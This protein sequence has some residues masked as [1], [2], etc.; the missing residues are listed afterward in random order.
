MSKVGKKGQAKKSSKSAKATP[1]RPT[2]AFLTPAM[3][4]HFSLAMWTAIVNAA[5][6]QDANVVCVA[7]GD[8][9]KSFEYA[10]ANGSIYQAAK[11]DIIDAVIIYGSR[12]GTSIPEKVFHAFCHQ[13]TEKPVVSIGQPVEGI[14]AVLSD[15]YFGMYDMVQHLIHEHG[16]RRIAFIRGPENQTEA[17][18]RLKAYNDALSE[19]GIQ[20]DLDL[21]SHPG[22]WE[23]SAG[24]DAVRLFIDERNVDFD[25]IV[26]AN[27]TMALA[28]MWALRNRGLDI[29]GD[30]AVV[31][32]DSQVIAKAATPPLSTVRQ[33]LTEQC[34]HAIDILLTKLQGGEV[35]DLIEIPTMLCIRQSCGCT[36]SAVGRTT[37]KTNIDMSDTA[38][39]Y[40]KR[41]DVIAEIARIVDSTAGRWK[42][43]WSKRLID[44]FIAAIE[45]KDIEKFLHDFS[46][47]IEETIS[48]ETEINEWQRV[49]TSLRLF[50]RS[51]YSDEDHTDWIEELC[52]QARVLIGEK[53]QQIESHQS[54]IYDR[55][56]ANLRDMTRA[57]STTHD[58]D[59]F[60]EILHGNLP[61]FG[62]RSCYLSLY[63]ETIQTQ[64]DH[65]TSNPGSRRMIMA[66][67][68]N[69]RLPL[70]DEASVISSNIIP[71]QEL[72]SRNGKWSF[73]VKALKRGDE[74]L[75][76]VLFEVYPPDGRSCDMLQ[77]QISSALTYALLLQEKRQ[78]QEIL[79]QAY[80]EAEQ[81]AQEKTVE[82][83]F[84]IVDLVQAQ[85][86]LQREQFLMNTLMDQ[87]LD[88]IYF[89]DKEGRFIKVNTAFTAKHGK[90]TPDD[91]LGLTVFDLFPNEQAQKSFD[92][93]MHLFNTGEPLVG[94][95][96]KFTLPDGHEVWS[97]TT[98]IPL[99]N[100]E[101]E[102][103]GLF[104]IS[105]DI[106][107]RVQAQEAL[108]R[109]QYLLH[110]LMNN[111]P[112][113]IY[114]KD[115][116]SRFIKV[117]T[118]F[119][120]IHDKTS[121]DD[122]LG[123]TDFDLF[124]DEHAQEAYDDEMRV[125]NT[126]EPVIGKIE[127]ETWPDGRETWVSTSKLPLRDEKGIITGTFGISRDITET[128][129]AEQELRRH[130]AHL[131]A[132]NTI[133]SSTSSAV[134]YQELLKISLD[135]SLHALGPDMGLVWLNPHTVSRKLLPPENE[136]PHY[137]Y[138]PDSDELPEILVV[139]E[140]QD[141]PDDDPC[142]RFYETFLKPHGVRAS[143][144]VPIKAEEG[145]S[146]GGLCIAS[147]EPFNW[148]T[149]ETTLLKA[150][151]YQVGIASERLRLVETIREQ[152][153]QVQQIT[154]T[155]PDGVLLLDANNRVILANPAGTRDLYTL[156]KTTVGNEITHLGSCPIS[157]VLQEDIDVPWHEINANNRIFE[158]VAQP[159][160]ARGASRNWVVVIRDVTQERETQRQVQL[161]ER[162]AA[163]GQL[164]GGIAHDFNNL[165]TTIMLYA[166][167]PLR[168]QQ[169]P[170]DLK[171]P[172]ET[173][174]GESRKAADLVQQI[175]DF[176]RHAPIERHPIDLG[177]FVKEAIRV[178]QRTIP[179]NISLYIE[180]DPDEYIVEA[181]P[182]RI[183]QVLMN[184]VV[185]ARDAMQEGGVLRVGVSS[186]IVKEDDDDDDIPTPGMTPGKWF[187]LSV[188][189]TGSGIPDDI[190]P[191]I[192][193]PF[194]TTKSAGKGTGLG[195]SQVWGIVVQHEGF[196]R[197]ESTI[198]EGTEFCVYLPIRQEAEDI[199]ARYSDD[200][201]IPKGA[202]ERILL[203]ED[204]Q[205][206]R[207][208]SEELLCDLGY[209]VVT[210]KNGREALEIY[211]QNGEFDLIFTDVVMP[212][213]G[214]VAL[215]HSL[216]DMGS[217]IKTIAVTG[218]MLAE[219][220]QEL[221][222]NG[223]SGI[224]FK[225]LEV[226]EVAEEL[227]RIL[228]GNE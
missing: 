207:E 21:I 81:Q 215:L 206:V 103:I 6:E 19:A 72:V 151:G 108:H 4:D 73:V 226:K 216:R 47:C 202:G 10:N 149:E 93:D 134:D 55:Q 199:Q 91:L 33:Q 187:C 127:K 222:K 195:L 62:I 51:Q 98:K 143:I 66:F 173:I 85:E 142:Y 7:G 210:A 209:Q 78:E 3:E 107:E 220:L 228:D 9:D 20:H 69:S 128:K 182:T 79:Q 211:K 164:A 147:P 97:S 27:D 174:L 204:S 129:L 82:L 50:T 2:I 114:F 86:A 35:S 155:V 25:A 36:S 130:A 34:R 217:E 133:I 31:G 221:R 169:L 188:K 92:D 203:V 13:F 132:I 1:A 118:A 76:I 167:M 29:P 30:V 67:D 56:Y 205:H 17:E 109:E 148:T 87:T 64:D 110:I 40:S 111:S 156:A 8:L 157:E 214:G 54:L 190:L 59:Q 178:L 139:G 153:Q 135:L 201:S 219:D 65:S 183:Q 193:E 126:G 120:E 212:E 26:S 175:L 24:E 105:R 161:Q 223:V 106:T 146:V 194:F 61:R 116:E 208:V 213:V 70:E 42:T 88:S 192:F 44:S 191:H 49:V 140:W 158:I 185:N 23:P 84:E 136:F 150:V 58:L 186:V 218:H 101:G 28:A 95:E 198:G 225:P 162:L 181:D 38:V 224:I 117:N 168:K 68:E 144:N 53:I 119:A 122:L 14:P 197:V 184:L 48:V 115:K 41:D 57:L 37:T 90:G 165:L 74:C 196:I 46:K 71:H 12:L 60:L 171:K 15:N 125:L 166:Q 160:D 179:E 172:L 152:M 180:I 121:P 32:F 43:N 123:L 100:E 170:A 141:I 77:E 94:K 113:A 227:R 159:I 75:G 138:N 99:R 154:D 52:S 189:D 39:S 89:N 45:E 22:N 16:Y 176:S 63:E 145:N 18:T 83:E 11:E 102:I 5:H 96:E 124:T 200:A 104:G 80:T 163:V 131:E 112:D 137:D 177:P